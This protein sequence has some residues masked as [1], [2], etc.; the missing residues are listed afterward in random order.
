MHGVADLPL[1]GGHVPRWMAEY[2]KR[3]ARAI[4]AVIVEEYGPNSLVE[5]LADP[6]W[7][8]AFNNAIGMD[9]D[10]SGS[11][12]VTLGILRQVLD[13]DPGLGVTVVGGKGVLARRVPEELAVKAERIGA[14]S[15]AAREAAR[16]SKLAAK[17]DNVLLQDGYTLYHH[18]VILSSNGEW[19]IVQQ[20]MNPEAGFARRYHWLSPLPATP[21]LEPHHAIAAA[22]REERVVDATSRESLE[23]RRAVLD[24]A[25]QDPRRTIREVMEAYALLKGVR[26]LTYWLGTGAER[27]A[28][29]VAKYYRPQDK[30]PRH[31]G[32]VLEKLYELQPRSIEEL[33]IVEGVGPGVFRS[34]ALVSELIYGY[35]MS[36][37]DPAN[38]PLDPFRYAYVVGGKDGVPFAFDPRL[39]EEVV[40]FLEDAISRARMGEKEKLRALSRLYRLLPREPGERI[41]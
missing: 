36:H 15:A 37:R 20:G 33:V 41:G 31:I 34:L 21:T 14:P 9:W 35:P 40:S 27:R 2:M 5:R 22:R 19:A 10:S 3:L 24:L 6:F 30:P 38:T 4:V 12:T 17:T 13:S 7:F 16:A 11:T 18:A 29:L 25:R 39:A 1:H 26:P 32:R 8:Q 28:R 23:A